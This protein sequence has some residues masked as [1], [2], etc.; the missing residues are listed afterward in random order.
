MF[1]ALDHLSQ[2]A[3]DCQA[4]ELSA[5]RTNVVFGEG[6]PKAEIA[7]VGEAPGADEDRSGKP[8]V[9][10]AGGLLAGY[11]RRLEI[12]RDEVYI[13][14]ILKCRPPGNRDPKPDEIKACSCF[15]HLQLRILRPKVVVALGRFAGRTLA[16]LP[17]STPLGGMREMELSYKCH[18]TALNCPLLVTYHPAFVL[19]QQRR[20]KEDAKATARMILHDLEK[21]K[22]ISERPRDLQ[23]TN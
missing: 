20:S 12:G 10:R 15:L 1:D 11:L 8:F 14:N 9:G 18:G 23:R 21:A 19:Y 22:G 13:C 2:I 3:D 4:C 17:A 6:H 7:F 5:V 16:G